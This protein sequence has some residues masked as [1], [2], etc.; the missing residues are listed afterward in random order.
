MKREAGFLTT[1]YIHPFN[2]PHHRP[3]SAALSYQIEDRPI[4][5]SYKTGGGPSET[6]RKVNLMAGKVEGHMVVEQDASVLRSSGSSSST[7]KLSIFAR[8]SSPFF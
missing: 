4:A 7:A 8:F 3:E 6:L 5:I 2:H 1:I